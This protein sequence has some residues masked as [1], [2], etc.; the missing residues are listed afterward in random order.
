M[1]Q[2]STSWGYKH[3]QSE[4]CFKGWWNPLIKKK[5]VKIS[6]KVCFVFIYFYSF[7]HLKLK[8]CF[9]VENHFLFLLCYY[10]SFYVSL[11]QWKFYI[12]CLEK[13]FYKE[14]LQ[15]NELDCEKK[16]DVTFLFDLEIKNR[17][18][19]FVPCKLFFISFINLNEHIFRILWI[20]TIFYGEFFF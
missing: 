8:K 10:Y 18:K 14:T 12:L 6:P 11:T 4:K 13:L 20:W 15:D 5:Y 19:Y 9:I 2:N 7:P 16:K 3:S 1:L 17:K